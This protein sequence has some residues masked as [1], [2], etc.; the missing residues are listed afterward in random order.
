MAITNKEIQDYI[1]QNI[2]D[3]QKIADAMQFYGVDAS[4]I[5]QATGYTPEQISSYLGNLAPQVATNEQVKDYVSQNLANPQNIASGLQQYGVTLDRLAEATG[6]S[7]KQIDDYFGSAG[8]KPVSVDPYKNYTQ[9][10]FDPTLSEMFPGKVGK[11]AY[12]SFYQNVP[13]VDFSK[14]QV[15]TGNYRTRD[16]GLGKYAIVD[17]NGPSGKAIGIGYKD[18]GQAAA[19]ISKGKWTSGHGGDWADWEALGQLL[20]NP[21]ADVTRR[22]WGSLPGN[23]QQEK[24]TGANTLYG[25]TPIFYDGK[26]IGYKSALTG[27]ESIDSRKQNYQ[28]YLDS[29]RSPMGYDDQGKPYYWKG[30]YQGGA[31]V[32]STGYNTEGVAV[33]PNDPLL[34]FGTTRTPVT[35]VTYED[36]LKMNPRPDQDL[37]ISGPLGLGSSHLGKSHSWATTLGRQLDPAQYKGLVKPLNKSDVFVPTANVSKLPGWTN[38]DSYKH[39]DQNYNWTS[40]MGPLLTFANIVGMMTTGVPIGSAVGAASNFIGGEEK[41]GMDH[42]K[43]GTAQFLGNQLAGLTGGESVLGTGVDLG[44]QALNSAASNAIAQGGLTSLTGGDVGKAAAMGAISGG[45]SGYAGATAKDL[46]SSL[47]N[48]GLSES[49]AKLASSAL[50]KTAGNVLGGLVYGQDIGQVL[51]NAVKSGTIDMISDQMVAEL[52]PKVGKSAANMIT[53]TALGQALKTI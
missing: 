30:E 51:E 9:Q 49:A 27:G 17:P 45:L 52:A 2:N 5:N 22:D 44:S 8:V 53:K 23:E 41:T 1:S 24:I 14:F 36:Y 16:I 46:T 35:N 32:I 34:P 42:L 48:Q 3:P 26:L 50:V 43:A 11:D 38:T 40:D 19:E 39:I 29:L 33:D 12:G 18:P 31:P 20:H 6:Y 25:S 13:G 21:N 37:T 10:Q 47:V 4:R 15:G 7:G 28:T